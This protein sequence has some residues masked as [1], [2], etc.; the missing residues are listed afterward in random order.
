M[1]NRIRVNISTMTREFSE[2]NN[3]QKSAQSSLNQLVN[4][5]NALS[6]S[7]EGMAHDA[8]VSTFKSDQES[9]QDTLNILGE[10]I[11]TLEE[12][13]DEYQKCEEQVESRISSIRV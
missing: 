4:A 7:W 9:M 12:A 2:M 11:S 5:I 6:A 8:L 1:G 10:Y 13:R 3:L